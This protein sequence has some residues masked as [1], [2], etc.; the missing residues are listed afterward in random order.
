MFTHFV[1]KNNFELHRHGR[2][3]HAHVILWHSLVPRSTL[4]AFLILGSRPK[5]DSLVGWQLLFTFIPL[6]PRLPVLYV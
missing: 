6:T 1:R 2:L 5:N 4:G 3:M